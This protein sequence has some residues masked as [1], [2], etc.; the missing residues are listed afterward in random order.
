LFL[1][2]LGVPVFAGLANGIGPFMGTTAGYL[3]GFVPAAMLGGFLARKGFARNTLRA[4][5]A[6]CLSAAV[7]F[8]CGVTVLAK[9]IGWHQAFLLGVAPFAL[10]ETLKLFSVALVVPRFWQ[11]AR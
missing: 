11:F 9:F 2:G 3:L 6:A 5:V 1:G 4:F 7:I 10:T 8:C